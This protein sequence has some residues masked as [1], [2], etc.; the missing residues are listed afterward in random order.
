MHRFIEK[1]DEEEKPEDE[2]DDRTGDEPE[3]RHE[4]S[5]DD[6]SEDKPEKEAEQKFYRPGG[7]DG[8]DK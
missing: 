4:G 1:P 2:S 5:G 3:Q 7:F 8:E 6:S